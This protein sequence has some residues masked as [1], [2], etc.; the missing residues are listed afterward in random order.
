MGMLVS[1]GGHALITTVFW[2]ML[3]IHSKYSMPDIEML[4]ATLGARESIFFPDDF[5]VFDTRISEVGF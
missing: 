4:L 5:S 1:L 3:D 2:K